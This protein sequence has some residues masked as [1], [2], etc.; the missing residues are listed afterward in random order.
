MHNAKIISLSKPESSPALLILSK[1]APT[2][3]I[4]SCVIK[5][6][7]FKTLLAVGVFITTKEMNLPRKTKAGIHKIGRRANIH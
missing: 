7:D 3:P 1:D 2:L 4:H 6:Q 5:K